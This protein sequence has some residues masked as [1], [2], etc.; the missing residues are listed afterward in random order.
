MVVGAVS[1]V[2]RDSIA[3]K[4]VSSAVTVPEAVVN[5]A[6][7]VRTPDDPLGMDQAKVDVTEVDTAS[8]NSGVLA[9]SIWSVFV[10]ALSINKTEVVEVCSAPALIVSGACFSSASVSGANVRSGLSSNKPW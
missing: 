7:T 3:R 8:V 5:L 1:S 10:G 2:V 9:I 4:I 6:Y